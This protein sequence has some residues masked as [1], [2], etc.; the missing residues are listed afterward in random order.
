MQLPPISLRITEWLIAWRWP[1]LVAAL[2]LTGVSWPVAGKIQFDRS[3]ENMFAPDDPLLAPYRKL[4]QTFGGDEVVVV[5]YVDPNLLSPEGLERLHQ[6]TEKLQA[7]PGVRKRG[8]LGLDHSPFR[9]PRLF[10]DF[11]EGMAIGADHETTAILCRLKSESDAWAEDQKTR[12][13]TVSMIRAAAAEHD[14][15][16]VVVGE[17]VMVLDGFDYLERDGRLLAQATT[18]LLT[19]VIILFFRSVRWVVIPLAVVQATLLWTQASLVAMDARLSMVSSMLTAI[20]TVVGIGTVIHLVI[21]F[22]SS[23]EAGLTSREALRTSG[24]L[25]LAPIV[26][27]C[28]TDA[29]GFG[30]LAISKVGPVKSFGGMTSLGAMFTAV[31]VAMLVPGLALIA[32]RF[33]PDPKRAWGEG[34]VERWLE[35]LARFVEARP[36]GV[37]LAIL[38]ITLV[39]SGGLAMLEVE[40]DFTK[41]FR[42]NSPIV[43][44]YRFVEE[45]LGGAGAWD[46]LIPIPEG[47]KTKEFVAFL[48]RVRHLED[49]LRTEVLVDPADPATPGLTKVVGLT[50]A[51]DAVVEADPTG[52]L[53]RRAA[54]KDLDF[55]IGK[56]REMVPSFADAVYAPDPDRPGAFMLRIMLRSR[57]QQSTRVKTRLIAHVSSIVAEEFPATDKLPAAQVTGF[58]VLLANLIESLMSDQWTSFSIAGAGIFLMLIV[59]LRSVKLSLV[60]LFPNALPII[61]VLGA[62]GWLGFKVNMGTVM[63]ASVSMGL[64]VDSSIHYLTAYRRERAAGMTFTQAVESVHKSVG[65]AMV[66]SNL[67]LIVGFSALGLSHFI[68]TIYFGVLVS[69]AMLGG[70]AGNLVLLPLELRWV[71]PRE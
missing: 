57:E 40:T 27:S 45:R 3:I 43:S 51:I 5:A 13:E 30:S 69:L 60:A 9:L 49:R 71:E 20:V 6:L 61:V 62:M 42:E 15:S 34:A 52:V 16:A 14:K 64:A 24:A 38:V 67:A 7:I 23:R 12:A 21:Q 2:I 29:V 11:F 35:W 31:A 10:L 39:S 18:G 55:M 47:Q 59:A 53:M 50:D 36:W 56:L 54:E 66:L 63:I 32:A 17:P 65:L 19:L 1:L 68:P 41:N 70:L 4:K 25:L 26:W 33:D 46:V 37:G 58:F 8:V 28:A 44:S 22:R 48:N